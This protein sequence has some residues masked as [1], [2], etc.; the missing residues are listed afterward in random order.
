M[1]EGDTVVADPTA[2][3][4]GR[5]AYVCGPECAATA[6]SRRA[7]GRAFRRPVPNPVNLVES[8]R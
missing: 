2:T 4:P 7:L 1:L 5:G 3:R 8:V 6:V